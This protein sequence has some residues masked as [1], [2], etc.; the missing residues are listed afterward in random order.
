MYFDLMWQFAINDLRYK[1]TK[2]SLN[3]FR[4]S[5]Q[6]KKIKIILVDVSQPDG[7]AVDEGVAT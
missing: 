1:D 5:L 7:L 2:G 3:A 4:C 6:E